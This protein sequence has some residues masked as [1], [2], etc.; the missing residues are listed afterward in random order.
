MFHQSRVIARIDNQIAAL[1]EQKLRVMAQPDDKYVDGDVVWFTKDFGP[2]GAH[3]YTY[4]ALKH[5]GRWYITQSD[6]SQRPMSWE[7][8]LD[9]VGDNELWTAVEWECIQ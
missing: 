1:E 7:T 3:P 8:L 4:A 9:F 5:G 2:S 6:T